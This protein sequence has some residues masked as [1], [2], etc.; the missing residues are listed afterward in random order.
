MD[1]IAILLCGK[2]AS[3]KTTLAK[4]LEVHFTGIRYGT[5]DSRAELYP[6]IPDLADFRGLQPHEVWPA[7]I[8]WIEK[9]QDPER[10]NMLYTLTP[11][12]GITPQEY[13]ELAA[14]KL[15]ETKN[16]FFIGRNFNYPIALEGALKLKEISYIHAEGFSAGELKHGPFALLTN[17]T[18]V[19]AI[20]DRHDN[21]EKMM[22]NITEIKA[23]GAPVIAITDKEDN[24]IE[25]YVDKT[26]KIPRISRELSPLL[27]TIA[28]Q[29]FAY[30]VANHK[31]CPIDKPRNLAKSVTVE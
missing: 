17:K 5:D 30:Y 18:P 29:L 13:F 14:K 11:T 24:E 6:I 1:N 26:F 10:I 4:R 22:T 9:Q 16:L 3:G 23:R 20:C 25:K 28:C 12:H 27:S 8:T 7:I 31:G 15:K 21:Y 19:V 2:P